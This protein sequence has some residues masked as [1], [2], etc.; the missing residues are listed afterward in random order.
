[1]RKIKFKYVKIIIISLFLFIFFSS[2]IFAQE[3]TQKVEQEE[4][5]SADELITQNDFIQFQR[6]SIWQLTIINLAFLIICITII[7]FLGG[8]F[9]LFNLKPLEEKINQM[10][11]N[12]RNEIT[13]SI[14][15]QEKKIEI[16]ENKTKQEITFIKEKSLKDI[17]DLQNNIREESRRLSKK[18]EEELNIEIEKLKGETKKFKEDINKS[19]SNLT[20]KLQQIEMDTQWNEH[21]VWEIRGV[22]INVLTSLILFIELGIKYNKTSLFFLVLDEI[23][24]TLDVLNKLSY[25]TY[26]EEDHMKL[27]KLLKEIKDFEKEKEEILKK[28]ENLFKKHN[29]KEL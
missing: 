27:V 21:Y 28:A 10:E 9:Y 7:L 24:K 11:K 18:I 5:L 13:K 1:M 15:N 14:N 25:S 22:H 6:E 16:L 3:K 23:N 4:I 2:F 20:A 26:E 8:I 17:S 12:L 19:L 29:I